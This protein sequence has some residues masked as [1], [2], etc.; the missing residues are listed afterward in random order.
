MIKI[1]VLLFDIL[2]WI[3]DT[4]FLQYIIISPF[5]TYVNVINIEVVANIKGWTM[6]S[7]NH[8]IF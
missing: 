1:I 6:V 7:N 8:Q 3:G 4:A 5:D 2:L